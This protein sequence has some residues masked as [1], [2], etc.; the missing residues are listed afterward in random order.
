VRTDGTKVRLLIVR[1]KL[2]IFRAL[3]K[4]N[5]PE[6]IVGDFEFEFSPSLA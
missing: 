3:S 4:F 1:K 2:D 6:A 5:L